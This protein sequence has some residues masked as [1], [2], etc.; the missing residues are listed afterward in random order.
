MAAQWSG[1]ESQAAPGADCRSE[2]LDDFLLSLGHELRTPI[3][4]IVGWTHLLSQR[5]LP[6]ELGE[7]LHAIERNARLQAK[8]VDDLLD[9]NRILGGRLTLVYRPLA[10]DRLLGTAI[11]AARPVAEGKG[12]AM[13]VSLSEPPHPIMGDAPRLEQ[14]FAHVLGNA[15]KFT[16]RDGRIAVSTRRDG[17]FALVTIADTGEGIPLHQLP[18]VFERFRTGYGAAAG[19]RHSGLGMGLALAKHLVERHGGTVT[20]HSDGPGAGTTVRIRL[21]LDQA[22][23]PMQQSGMQVASVARCATEPPGPLRLDGM[24]VLLVEDDEDSR[25][26]LAEILRNAGATCDAAGSGRDALA[27]ASERTGGAPRRY[28]CMVLDLGLPDTDGCRLLQRLGAALGRRGPLPPAIALTAFGRAADRE[29]ALQAG[30]A[31]YSQKPL[32]P[33]RLIASIARLA[34]GR[35]RDT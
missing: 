10:L 17:S 3:N 8:L 6:P 21:P 31:E 30:F 2:A 12:V 26:V 35:R 9:V 32:Q 4:A 27:L 13:E 5:P 22:A 1:H 19:H 24:D 16:A 29:R 34:G 33:E 20:V 14:V 15:I 28:D 23:Q 25:I 18:H 7:G 11:A